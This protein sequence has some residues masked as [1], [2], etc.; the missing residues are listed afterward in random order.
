VVTD[1][2][3]SEETACVSSKAEKRIWA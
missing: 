3:D 2:L 1:I